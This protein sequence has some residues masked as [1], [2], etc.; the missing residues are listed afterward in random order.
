MTAQ[1]QNTLYGG[2]LSRTLRSSQYIITSLKWSLRSRSNL[3]VRSLDGVLSASLSRYKSTPS[4]RSACV[5]YERSIID[6]CIKILCFCETRNAGEAKRGIVGISVDAVCGRIEANRRY[7]FGTG[8]EA[9][10]VSDPHRVLCVNGRA[11]KC[12]P[13]LHWITCASTFRASSHSA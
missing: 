6:F 7:I 13:L 1:S 5:I 9:S 2:Y 3:H 4:T 8:P 12:K 10:G 11:W